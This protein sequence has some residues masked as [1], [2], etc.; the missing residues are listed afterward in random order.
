MI[1]LNINWQAPSPP[2]FQ[3]LFT[4][5]TVYFLPPKLTCMP[6]VSH[7][8]S[9]IYPAARS[10]FLKHSLHYIIPLFQKKKK[11]SFIHLFIIHS[12]FAGWSPRKWSPNSWFNKICKAFHILALDY[13][14]NFT[15]NYSTT[16]H[17]GNHL[18]CTTC[19]F[20]NTC[21]FIPP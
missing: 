12:A 14:S 11:R 16:E 21:V 2:S 15:H 4:S 13:P 5:C 3:D 9:I 20:Q 18:N 1:D 7:Y 10:I 8:Q 17:P 6:S 19:S